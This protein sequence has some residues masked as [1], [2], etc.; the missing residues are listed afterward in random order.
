MTFD[1]FLDA[2]LTGLSKYAV[3][4]TGSRDAAHDVLADSLV[5]AHAAWRRIGVMDHAVAYVRRIVTTTYLSERR[6]WSV[7]AVRVTATGDLPDVA[8][9]D[10]ADA[11]CEREHLGALLAALPR[12]QRAAV[13]LRYYLGLDNAA[14]ATE[15]GIS[16]GAARTAV[17]RGLAALRLALEP[18]DI[19]DNT[20]SGAR[21]DLR[22]GTPRDEPSDARTDVRAGLWE[23]P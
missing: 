19:P 6:R 12:Q 10:P 8:L 22:A 16:G 20:A 5:K 9:P 14:I 18:A 15:L 3:V 23:T 21:A 7:R 2:E 11:W 13:V 1:E 4:L 17:S